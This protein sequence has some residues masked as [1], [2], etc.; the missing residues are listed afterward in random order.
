MPNV[1]FKHSTRQELAAL[2]TLSPF[3]TSQPFVPSLDQP[4][5]GRSSY[6]LPAVPDTSGT[7]N[8][9]LVLLLMGAKNK[10]FFSHEVSVLDWD[11]ARQIWSTALMSKAIPIPA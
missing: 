2:R 4:M 1:P 8:N 7:Y 11:M 10:R 3:G 5:A 9:N 6:L